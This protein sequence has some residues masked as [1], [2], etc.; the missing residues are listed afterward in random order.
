MG[1]KWS[2]WD[3]DQLRELVP[4]ARTASGRALWSPNTA[5]VKPISVVRRLRQELADRGVKMLQGQNEFKAQPTQQQL[6]LSDGTTLNYGHLFQLHRTASGSSCKS[7][8]NRESVHTVAIQG[9]L[10]ATERKLP[11]P[12]KNKSVSGAR[13]KRSFLGVHFTPSADETPVVSIGPTATLA[14][15]RENYRGFKAIEPGMAAS[16]HWNAC[17]PIFGQQR[18]IPSLCA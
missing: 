17:S 2:S 13:S 6:I 9:A 7:F 4:E 18:W 5:V 3:A 14:F 16:K 15:G 8:W 10:L 12:T 1:R 11:F